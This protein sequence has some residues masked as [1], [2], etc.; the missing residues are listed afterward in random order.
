MAGAGLG[1]GVPRSERG[2]SLS[3][4]SGRGVRTRGLS[5]DARA[6]PTRV[7]FLSPAAGGGKRSPDRQQP[8]QGQGG[9]GP[10]EPAKPISQGLKN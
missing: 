6:A 8:E 4:G 9:P 10:T 2:G 5:A 7:H 3:Q 1:T